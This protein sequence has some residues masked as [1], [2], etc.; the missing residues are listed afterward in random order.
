MIYKKYPKLTRQ[1]IYAM[2]SKF[3][4]KKYTYFW[5]KEETDWLIDNYSTASQQEITE[6]YHPR[7]NYNA[8]RTKAGKLGLSKDVPPLWTTEEDEIMIAYYPTK[9]INEVLAMLPGRTYNSLVNRSQILGLTS[10]YCLREKYTDEQEQFIIENYGKL[11]DQEIAD[12]LNKPLSGIQEKRRRLGYYYASKDYS[13][14]HNIV[15]LFR[16]HI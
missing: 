12:I 3:K 4:R 16:G 10:Y 6:H 2:A 14:Y 11:T 13:K 9:P 5:T 7:H 8:V 15:K 1:T